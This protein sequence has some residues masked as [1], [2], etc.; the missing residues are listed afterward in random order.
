MARASTSVNPAADIAV[1]VWE[2]VGLAVAGIAAGVRTEG[3][4][5]ATPGALGYPMPVAGF[6]GEVG[7]D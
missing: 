6:G 2:V 7:A 4:D 3:P 1:G 5:E